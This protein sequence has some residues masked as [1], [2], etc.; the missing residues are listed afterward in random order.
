M[1]PFMKAYE[2]RCEFIRTGFALSDDPDTRI[3]M[4]TLLWEKAVEEA[5]D[6]PLVLLDGDTL[7]TG[8]VSRYFEECFDIG[9]TVKDEQVPINSGVL[10]VKT[11]K[12]SR[13]FFQKWREQTIALLRDPERYD[14]SIRLC[15]GIDQMAFVNIIG[16][17]R[18]TGLYTV[19]YGV[20]PLAVK[21]FPCS[22]LNQTRS[23][24]VVPETL[25]YHYK[26][27]WRRIL[28]DGG[29]FTK[30]RPKKDSF[31]M[32]LLYMK[33]FLSAV[34]KIVL[35]EKVFNIRSMGIFLPF[36]IA[37]D[38]HAIFA[39]YAMYVIIYRLNK[40]SIKLSRRIFGKKINAN[41]LNNIF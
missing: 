24:P 31:E 18:Q 11:P 17:K 12:N 26:G 29:L 8:D 20:V 4:K 1:R 30:K 41:P 9:F 6:R 39:G 28:T 27:G 3:S 33:T 14:E 21:A 19:T 32:Y 35:K 2:D 16:F 5:E 25:I 15:G 13:L 40:I 7:V 22:V 38:G 10:L 34:D 36:Y 23:A 37:S